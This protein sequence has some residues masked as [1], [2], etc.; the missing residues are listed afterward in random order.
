MLFL[1]PKNATNYDR[2]IVVF[3]ADKSEGD[4]LLLWGGTKIRKAQK[5]EEILLKIRLF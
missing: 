3:S 2:P 5:E 1:I 4:N